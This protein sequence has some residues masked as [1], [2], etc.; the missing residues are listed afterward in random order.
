[1][2]F[3]GLLHYITDKDILYE[4]AFYICRKY[5]WFPI[6]SSVFFMVFLFFMVF[7]LFFTVFF[8]VLFFVDRFRELCISINF[9][10]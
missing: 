9:A 4:Y 10:L 8:F 7:V 1:M 5:S 2:L 3:T 6:L